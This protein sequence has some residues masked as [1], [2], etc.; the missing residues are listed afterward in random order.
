MARKKWR[1]LK[2]GHLPEGVIERHAIDN[3]IMLVEG[4]Q[5]LARVGIP[6]FTSSIVGASDELVSALVKG[7]VG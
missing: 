7:T 4:E 5:L 2:V 3:I 6:N 1:I